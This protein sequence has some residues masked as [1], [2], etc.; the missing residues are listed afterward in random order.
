MNRLISILFVLLGIW[1]C[2]SKPQATQVDEYDLQQIKESDTLT[3]LTLS[4]S[5]SYFDYKGEPMGFQYELAEQFA[6]YIGV[7]LEIKIAPN[8]KE[9]VRMLNDKEGDLIA[10]YLPITKE[11]KEEIT[12]CGEEVVTHQV[13]VQKD[14]KRGL[15]TDVTELIGKEVY[16]KPGKYAN[17]LTNLNQELG[18]GIQIH[19]VD[20]DSISTEDLV[21]KVAKGEIDYTVCDND[22]ARLNK[23]Y[24]TNLHITLPIGFDQRASW[25]TRKSSPLLAAI[26]TKWHE[27]NATSPSYLA[28]AKRYFE[29]SKQTIHSSILSLKEGKISHFDEL[30]KKYAKEIDWDWRLLAALAYTESNFDTTAVSWAGAQGLMQLMPRTARAMGVPPG[31]EHNPEE[32]IKAAVKYIGLTRRTFQ[33]IPSQEEQVLF[34][35]AAYNAG[36]G[37]VLDAMALAEKY[38]K[39]RYKWE[40][41]VAEYL[42]LKS[43]EEYFND[44]VCK[45]GYL[46]GSET[47]AFVHDIVKRADNYRKKV[48]E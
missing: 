29:K 34:T 28:S 48:K 17:R 31:K 30:F 11:L 37:H 47:Y 24:Y 12:F 8:V 7:N 4:G 46:R 27:E 22:L 36:L 21:S 23:T 39:N 16:V 19:L 10:Y 1:G 32:S 26:A 2:S 40:G 41:N 45:N 13:L 42:L 35:L 38:G 9:L 15:I 44:S 3:V 14:K 20:N 25:A 18:G 5:T 33:K 43:H 6:Q